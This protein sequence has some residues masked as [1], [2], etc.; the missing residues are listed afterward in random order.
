MMI[1]T[2]IDEQLF[3]IDEQRKWFPEMEFTA[4]ED[5]MKII[6]ISTKDLE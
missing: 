5:T 6:E 3:L 1:K 2:L 4:G